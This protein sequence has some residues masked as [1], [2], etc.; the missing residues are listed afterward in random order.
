MNFY[1]NRILHEERITTLEHEAQN[2]GSSN[3]KQ[4]GRTLRTAPARLGNLFVHIGTKMQQNT[5]H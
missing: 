3:G 2:H 1:G 5:D 4:Y